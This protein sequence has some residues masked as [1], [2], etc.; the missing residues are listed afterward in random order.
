MMID[1]AKAQ[2]KVR[3]FFDTSIKHKHRFVALKSFMGSE[4]AI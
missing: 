3:P 2:K 4:L 1:S